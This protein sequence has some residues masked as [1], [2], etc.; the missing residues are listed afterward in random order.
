[1]PQKRAAYKEIRK[2]AKKRRRNENIISEIKTLT[3]KFNAFLSEKKFDQAK[4]SLRAV[5]S[6]FGKASVKGV[7]RKNTASRK[8]S[9]LSK[10]LHKAVAA[11]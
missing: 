5:S 2:S 1:M 10:K 3:K 6:G 11:K 4:E 9:R 7:I 8:I